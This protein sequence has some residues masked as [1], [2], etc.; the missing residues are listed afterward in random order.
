MKW[1]DRSLKSSYLIITVCTGI[2]L[3]S[4][5]GLA[6]GLDVISYPDAVQLMSEEARGARVRADR[7]TADNGRILT[8][9]RLNGGI[10]AVLQVVH[11]LRGLPAARRTAD[12][13]E[14]EPVELEPSA[15]DCRDE[16]AS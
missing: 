5:R 10:E 6:A 2:R 3:L 16:P 15:Q 7:I 12:R 4:T 9:S 14:Y 11:H 13:I 8:S 1:I